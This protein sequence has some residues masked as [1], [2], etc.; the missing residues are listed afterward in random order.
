VATNGCASESARR[1]EVTVT[2]VMQLHW[3]G[4]T[5]AQY[6]EVRRI[7][8]WEGD[9]P[10]G[11]VLH[12]AWFD[13]GLRVWDVWE[14]P[15]AFER[16]TTERL[17]PGVS[18]AG[19]VG[20]PMLTIVPCHGFQVEAGDTAGAVVELDELPTAGYDAIAAE[21]D[22]VATPPIGGIVHIA[23]RVDDD[24]VRAL[25]VWQDAAAHEAFGRDR[26]GPAAASLGIPVPAGEPTRLAPVHAVVDAA[27]A[28]AA[29]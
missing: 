3:L 26:V 7:V 14:S 4:V 29:S 20:E 1:D 23:A 24:T 5:P 6:D 2:I 8:D 19:V 9:V 10:D 25:S 15:D 18:E 22:R 21:V 27:G 12:V 11:A 17:L 13:D 28:L 16:F